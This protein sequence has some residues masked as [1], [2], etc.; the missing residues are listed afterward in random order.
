M[1]NFALLLTLILL[2]VSCK[3]DT[4]QPELFGSIEGRVIEAR[5]DSLIIPIAGAS[6]STAPATT[7][8]ITD[9]N[10]EFIGR[11]FGTDKL[12]FVPGCFKLANDS[13]AWLFSHEVEAFAKCFIKPVVGR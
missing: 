8:W 10:G 5:D 11:L 6:V 3:E 9:A 1:T 4:I 2:I 13:T 7:S 12:P